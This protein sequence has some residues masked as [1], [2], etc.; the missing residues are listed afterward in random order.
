MI[1]SRI[2]KLEK[3]VYVNDNPFK[4]FS[5]SRLDELC[6]KLQYAIYAEMKD[7]NAAREFKSLFIDLTD[8]LKLTHR[9]EINPK[10]ALEVIKKQRDWEINRENSQKTKEDLLSFYDKVREIYKIFYNV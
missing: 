5:N 2:E 1:K 3:S 6:E 10:E 7:R 9:E 8:P 4:C